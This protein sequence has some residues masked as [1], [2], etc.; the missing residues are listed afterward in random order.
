MKSVLNLF[1]SAAVGIGLIV[2]GP[3]TARAADTTPLQT[4]IDLHDR[5][6]IV[7][8]GGS[9]AE[10]IYALGAGDRLVARDSTST[11]PPEVTELPDVGYMRQL[12][13]EGVLS[14]NPDG[15]IALD[16]S[17]PPETIAVLRQ[18]GVPLVMIPEG[19]DEQG[20]V[21]KIRRIGAA[22]GLGARARELSSR[23]RSDLAAL[24]DNTED[25]ETRK[26]VL[27]VL[28]AQNGKILAS[29]KGTAADG[30]IRLAGAVNAVEGYNG[31]K[32]LTDE[33][34][35]AARPDAVLMMDRG[36][37]TALTAEQLFASPALAT[38]PAGRE[39]N[40]IRMDGL[41]LLGFGPRTADAAR[42][43]SHALYGES[44]VGQGEEADDRGKR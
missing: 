19:Y 43:L 22:L 15:I 44:I 31:Y 1:G 40:L 41:Y 29:G 37:A 33:A 24:R 36:G 38:T 39:K 7:A 5:T 10:I 6:H 9:V 20:I 27:F 3:L 17:G 16:D 30:I 26:R 32:A 14:V 12:S 34:L 8:V 21:E 42:D 13:P 23:I 2:A 28:S 35:I 18:S 25:I 4:A 11:F